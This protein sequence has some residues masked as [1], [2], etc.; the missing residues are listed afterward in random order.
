MCLIS[1]RSAALTEM[2]RVLSTSTSTR[3]LGVL[4]L[5]L[6]LVLR[7]P[8]TAVFDLWAIM[9][10]SSTPWLDRRMQQL[11]EDANKHS[12][13]EEQ[14][15]LK[16]SK[17]W[18]ERLKKEFGLRFLMALRKC[19]SAWIQK[20]NLGRSLALTITLTINGDIFLSISLV[21]AALESKYWQ[22]RKTEISI[23]YR[24][25]QCAWYRQSTSSFP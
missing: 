25:L 19:H 8:C 2:R 7:P 10:R 1:K 21:S 3:I 9:E 20:K 23:A 15:N 22:T 11:L 13:I 16:F 4:A 12:P 14:L 24:H 6:L 18:A 5:L 17:S